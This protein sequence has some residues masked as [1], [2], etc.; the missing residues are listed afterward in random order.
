MA[1]DVEPHA[2]LPADVSY[3]EKKLLLHKLD[4][5]SLLLYTFLLTLTV[6]TIWL[7]KHRRVAFIHETGL[8]IVYGL[9]IGAIIRYG[10][11]DDY[12]VRRVVVKPVKQA[13][14]IEELKKGGPPD[15]LYLNTKGKAAQVEDLYINK[16]WV[17]DFKG[18][19]RDSKESDIDEKTTFDPEIFFNILLPPVIFHAGYAMKKKY[20][21]RNI[22]SI[23]T[24][25]FIGTAIST[26]TVGGFMYGVSQ[27]VPHL[28]NVTFI[29]NLHFGALISATDPVTILAIFSDL[30]VDVNLHALVFGESVL[31]DAVAIVMV[32]SIKDYEENVATCR[33]SGD[34][35]DYNWWHLLKAILDFFGIFSASFLVGSLM[36]CVT[37]LLTKFTQIRQH[38]LLETTL[39]VL[40][41]YSTFLLAEVFELTG[42]VSVLFCGICQAHYTYNNLS[43]ESQQST[44]HFFDI[45]NFMAEN[46]IFSYIGVSMFTFPNHHF[47]PV[48]II[49]AFVA[50]FIGRFLNV[51]PLSLLLNLGRTVRIT[52]GIQ[53]MM[54]FSGLR[55]AIAFALAIRNT[56]SEG[57]QMILSTTLVIVIA[58]V[59]FN[60]GCTMPVLSWLGIPTGVQEDPGETDPIVNSPLHA[61]YRSVEEGGEAGDAGSSGG[62]SLTSR[63]SSTQQRPEKS[64]LARQWAG[65]DASLFK[66]LL[67]H[68]SPTLLET[69]PNRC[70]PLSRLLTSKEQLAKH[71]MMQQEKYH[72]G[73]SRDDESPDFNQVVV[74]Q[75]QAA[76]KVG[77]M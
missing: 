4:S 12:Q 11:N 50:I 54:M 52:S 66:P 20:F 6:V 14:L 32:E 27:L 1:G 71:P 38:P 10:V 72:D 53:N 21:F 9:I 43:K 31:N 33:L 44:K 35:C 56:L 60:G 2:Y 65:V 46:F 34:P 23:F 22:G 51:Y 69:L 41:S 70:L 62:A 30:H 63:Q 61:G 76:T 49:G 37:A 57:R 48:Y 58:T 29:D 7:F 67:T 28:N 15:Q 75:P 73:A 47:D 74:D 17:Y 26:F 18:E 59:I 40:M 68:S 36:G 64:W 13:A 39:F 77:H 19:V 3:D 55:G 24:F 25:A 45:L 16:T 5:L 8:A 42:I